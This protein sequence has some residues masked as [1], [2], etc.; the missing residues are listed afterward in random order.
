MDADEKDEKDTQEIKEEGVACSK[1]CCEKKEVN[2]EIKEE[3]E[4]G[5]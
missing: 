2:L 3:K 1:G 5:C 4:D